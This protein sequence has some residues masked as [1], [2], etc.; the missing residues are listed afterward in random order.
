M[1][2]VVVVVVVVVGTRRE[3]RHK[4][5]MNADVDWL[6]STVTSQ[7]QARGAGYLRCSRR[8]AEGCDEGVLACLT[9]FKTVSSSKNEVV[10]VSRRLAAVVSVAAARRR[11]RCGGAVQ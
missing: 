8:E 11:R 5:I 4:I 3:N 10:S 9:V 1:F 2:V 6:A 7:K